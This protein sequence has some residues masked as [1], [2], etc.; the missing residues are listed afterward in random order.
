MMDEN[1]FICLNPSINLFVQK[2]HTGTE[3][4]SYQHGNLQLILLHN[5]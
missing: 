4:F 2:S 1:V 3:V 5:T